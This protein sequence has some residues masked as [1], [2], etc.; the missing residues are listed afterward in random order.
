VA[1]ITLSDL[2]IASLRDELADGKWMLFTGAG[3]SADAKDQDGCAIPTGEELR[4]ELWEL[5]FPGEE[6]DDSSLSDLYL[7]AQ[8]RCAGLLR[9][10]LRRRFTVDPKSLPHYYEAWL[11]QPWRRAYTLNVDDLEAAIMERFGLHRRVHAIS[12]LSRSVDRASHDVLEYVHLNGVVADAPQGVTFST[13]QYARRIT[14]EDRWYAQFAA[15]LDSSPFVFVGTKLDEPSIWQHL[16]AYAG[17]QHVAHSPRSLL[18]S[19]SLSRARA[20]L[21]DQWNIDWLCAS[22]RTFAETAL[23][24]TPV[25]SPAVPAPRLGAP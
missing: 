21:L 10:M 9:E 7:H 4:C 15:D 14:G 11:S 19:T 8:T 1:K 18:V 6:P 24:A 13:T 22:S 3:F 17:R 25:A 12:S 5:C 2:R 23:D 20:T 16:E